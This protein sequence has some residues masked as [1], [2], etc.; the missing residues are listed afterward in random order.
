M[1]SKNNNHYQFISWV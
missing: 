1:E